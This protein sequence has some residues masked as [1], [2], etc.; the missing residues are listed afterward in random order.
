MKKSVYKKVA[1]CVLAGVLLVGS[2]G[3]NIQR[4]DKRQTEKEHE[5]DKDNPQEKAPL[6]YENGK[7]L[8]L[9]ETLEDMPYYNKENPI[10]RISTITP[11]I[12]EEG[13]GK[14]CV[15]ICPGGG[16]ESL[17]TE[18]EG[19]APAEALN[20]QGI[21]AFVLKYRTAPYDYQAILSDVCRGVRYV[22]YHAEDFGINPERIAIMGFS[23]GGHLATMNLKHAA[24]DEQ[25]LDAIDE[26]NGQADYGILCYPVITLE[27]KYAHEGSRDA[28]LGQ[29]NIDNEMLAQKY[30]AQNDINGEMSPC[31]LWHCKGDKAVPYQNSQAFYNT[32]QKAGVNCELKLYENGA[33]GIGMGKEYPGANEW[34]SQCLE[35]LEEYGFYDEPKVAKDL[36]SIDAK[37]QEKSYEEELA[38]AIAVTDLG[39]LDNVTS[40]LILPVGYGIHIDIDWK[41]SDEDVVSAEGKVTP[42]LKKDQKV[43]LTATYASTKLEEKETKTYE[44]TVKKTTVEEILEKDAKEV[45]EY[46]DYI[47]NDGYS[48]PTSKEMDIFSDVTWEVKEGKAKIK[49]GK[50]VKTKDSKEREPIVLTARLKYKGKNKTIEL[51]NL[52]LI[53][54]YAAYI[55]SYFGGNGKSKEMYI[56]YSYDGIQWEKLN[57]G[58]V[59]LSNTESSKEMRD[60][61]IIRK[62]DG[63]FAVI[64]T[65]GWTSPYI[66]IWDSEDLVTF[67]N[68][69][70]VQ[71]SYPGVKGIVGHRAWAPEVNYDPI[72][73]LYYIYWSDPDSNDG[74]GKMYYNTS[75]DLVEVS[76]PDVFFEREYKV[77]DG[78]IKKYKGDY[79]MVYDDATG[80]NVTGN[81]GRMIY[82]AK[83]DSL[84]AGTF[85][86]YSAVLSEGMAEG[87]FLL[88]NFETGAWMVYF[89]YFKEHKYGYA[90]IDDLTKDDW[91]YEGVNAAMPAKDVR[92]G[93]AISVTQKELERILKA[94]GGTSKE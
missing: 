29:E 75:K 58:N 76:Q 37:Y 74:V 92:H 47:V 40:D 43:T 57:E 4:E 53:D 39:E 15:I 17:A 5:T 79:Y 7:G 67:E 34:F 1:V 64:A 38:E 11:Y 3:C 56:G 24:E 81:G 13:E 25:Q 72:T 89:D 48:L 51:E 77:I 88:Q 52:T 84:E 42:S 35:W 14:G 85:K 20:E 54:E 50:V 46:V 68:E 70:M 94:F 45:Q 63:S 73:D 6:E 61:M 90:T 55:L 30:S 78:S 19:T 32:M 87:P 65:D 82:M 71:V 80:D 2:C 86:P 59:V 60:P 18:K 49:N 91:S 62:K 31:F 9:W 23:A 33:H 12:S 28:F 69:R 36:K 41:S 10:Q 93:G 26:M 83:A 8:D 21:S 66:G 27:G 22:R 44:L 16:Y